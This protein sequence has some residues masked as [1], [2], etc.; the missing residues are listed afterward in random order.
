MTP[1]A[2][3]FIIFKIILFITSRAVLRSIIYNIFN[4]IIYNIINSIIYNVI[5][6]LFKSCVFL[7]I[8]ISQLFKSLMFLEI[9]NYNS[10]IYNII[11]KQLFKDVL[12]L[13]VYILN[14]NE[15][16][17]LNLRNYIK[18]RNNMFLFYNNHINDCSIKLVILNKEMTISIINKND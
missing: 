4:N 8:Y 7:K 9:C 2:V 10:I 3:L 12:S 1:R 16:T 17:G 6:Q 18:K 15:Q 13:K 11:K 14:E 5:K